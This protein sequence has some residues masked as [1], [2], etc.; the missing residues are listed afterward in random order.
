MSAIDFDALTPAQQNL[1][2]QIATNQDSVAYSN[3]VKS[4]MNKG[5]V[6]QYHEVDGAFRIERYRVPLPVHIQ[7]CEWCA[8]TLEDDDEDF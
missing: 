7:W 4:L 3:T 5:L 1:L 2:G 6:E 8:A